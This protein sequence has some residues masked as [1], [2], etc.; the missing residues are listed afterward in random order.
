MATLGAD[1]PRTF[2]Q[3]GG[4]PDYNEIPIIASDTV[5]AGAA[6]GESSTSG[7]GRPLVGAD[8]FKGFAIEQC[9]NEGGAASAK[10]IKLLAK[11]KVVL[12]VTGVD[13]ANDE[14]STVYASDDDTFTLTSSTGF[15][16]IGKV[17]RVISTSGL[18]LVRFAADYAR[19]L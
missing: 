12:T 4:H 5:Y 2:E 19:D 17:E 8:N 11:G 16:S 3:F 6:V 13:N 7:T 10:N 9:A 1:K 14:G 18:A 15:T